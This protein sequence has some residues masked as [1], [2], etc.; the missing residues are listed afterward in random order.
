MTKLDLDDLEAKAK[1]AVEAGEVV[2]RSIVWAQT[3]HAYRAA[4]NPATMLAL[5][6]RI[7][8]LEAREAEVR[9]R[10]LEEAAKVADRV[11]DEYGKAL[12]SPLL[13]M[14]DPVQA[15]DNKRLAQRCCNTVAA[16]IRSL[17]GTPNV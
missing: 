5:I 14:I 2:L 6:S 7:R 1:A 4:A 10:A 13:S 17:K 3:W 16:A 15:D 11:R 12:A 9:D 8:E